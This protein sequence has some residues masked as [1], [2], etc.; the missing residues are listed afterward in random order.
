M[1]VYVVYH[2]F[3]SLKR[4]N[5][6]LRRTNC[7]LW[8]EQNLQ[9]SFR[10][11][12]SSYDLYPQCSAWMHFFSN[13][14]DRKMK[15]VSYVFCPSCTRVQRFPIYLV[16]YVLSTKTEVHTCPSN[17][18]TSTVHHESVLTVL[19]SNLCNLYQH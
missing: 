6:C 15:N 19:L 8:Q 5:A 3:N 9:P 14:K 18:P 12:S 1:L 11:H 17:T 13:T 16:H 10:F 7:F 2:T 4:T